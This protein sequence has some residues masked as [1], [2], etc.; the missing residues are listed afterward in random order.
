MKAALA[1]Y[2]KAIDLSPR[3]FIA[4]VR[5]GV[6]LADSGKLDDALRDLNQAVALSPRSF[7]A[8]Y[9]RGRVFMQKQLWAE[10]INDLTRATSLKEKNPK[11]YHLLG[12]AYSRMGDEEKALLYWELARR[13]EKG[14]SDNVS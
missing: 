4:W 11:P 9:N 12:D 3:L 14:S 6:T 2:N 5:R 8:I 10:A 7:K 13:F 1:N